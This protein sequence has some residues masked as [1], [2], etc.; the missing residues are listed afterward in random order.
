[1]SISA[2]HGAIH[3]E[4]EFGYD[5]NEKSLLYEVNLH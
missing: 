3:E 1:M 5:P 4:K 2:P